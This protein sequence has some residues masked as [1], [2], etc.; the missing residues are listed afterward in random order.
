MKENKTFDTSTIEGLKTAERYKRRLENKYDKVRT[1][2]VGLDRVRIE[3]VSANQDL[4]PN[5]QAKTMCSYK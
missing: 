1:T 3:G 2:P 4:D 5:A